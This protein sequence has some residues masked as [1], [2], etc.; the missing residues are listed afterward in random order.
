LKIPVTSSQIF[1]KAAEKSAASMLCKDIESTGV[2]W[3]NI[4]VNYTAQKHKEKDN[5]KTNADNIIRAYADK[6][7]GYK[8]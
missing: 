8:Q 7:C 4:Y 1:D 3:Y 6:L 2:L 5:E